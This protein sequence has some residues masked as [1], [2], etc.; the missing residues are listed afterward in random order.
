MPSPWICANPRTTSVAYGPPGSAPPILPLPPAPPT[1]K[2]AGKP[3]TNRKS[4]HERALPICGAHRRGIGDTAPQHPSRRAWPCPR[5]H[6]SAAPG[7]GTHHSCC[8]GPARRRFAALLYT[9]PDAKTAVAEAIRQTGNQQHR[10]AVETDNARKSTWRERA[11]NAEDALKTA[12]TDFCFNATAFANCSARSAT[13]KP[14]GHAMSSSESPPRTPLLN[15]GSVSPS[16][17]I[18]R[19]TNDSKPPAPTCASKTVESPTSKPDRLSLRIPLRARAAHD[20]WQGQTSCL[21][22]QVNTWWKNRDTST[23]RRADRRLYHL[24]HRLRYSWL[25]LRAPTWIS[26]RL[27]DA[28]AYVI[29]WTD[30]CRQLRRQGSTDPKWLALNEF[31]GTDT[32]SSPPTTAITRL[33]TPT[34]DSRL[35]RIP[36]RTPVGSA[37]RRLRAATGTRTGTVRVRY[38]VYMTGEDT[39]LRPAAGWG[40]RGCKDI[41]SSGGATW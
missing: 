4:G 40:A 18:A 36:T 1:T 5:H 23:T 15:S 6:R 38:T 12:H 28:I 17:T 16:P 22:A 26:N 7:K 32:A 8:R 24:R 13:W 10:L 2:A 14:N 9:N 29:G 25:G 27:D 11:L 21:A 39:S 20:H 3:T 35:V 41:V 34:C 30:D 33:T 31:A 19:S 37:Q